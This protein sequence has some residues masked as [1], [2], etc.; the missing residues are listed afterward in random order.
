MLDG[1]PDLRYYPKP[2]DHGGIYSAM[3]L[4]DNYLCL[5][6]DEEII[7]ISDSVNG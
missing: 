2:D 5:N 3:L 1:S 6:L 7:Y 4:R